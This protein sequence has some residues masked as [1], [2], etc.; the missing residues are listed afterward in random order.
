[1]V[2]RMTRGSFIF[3]LLGDAV[4]LA[5]GGFVIYLTPWPLSPWVVVTAGVAILGGAWLCVTPFLVEYRATVKFA[6]AAVLTDTVAQIKRLERIAEQIGGATAQWQAAQEMADQTVQSSRQV[7]ERMSAEATAFAEFMQKAND[8]EK[9]HL[10]LEVEK[11]RRSEG[12]WLQVV[13]AMLDHVFALHQAAVR[14]RQPGLVEQLTHFQNACRDIARRV[15]LTPFAA[16]AGEAFDPQVHQVIDAAAEPGPG[17]RIGGVIATGYTFQGQPLRR[18]LV[19]LAI[20]APPAP[21]EQSAP[22]P[23]R[24]SSLSDL[25]TSPML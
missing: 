12:D 14:S 23:S 19:T 16:D 7:M 24:P 18:C 17:A 21:D 25:D 3:F 2:P 10:R 4:L 22:E 8:R 13:T 11:L 1:M 5:F 20:E 6:E 9:A 15:G